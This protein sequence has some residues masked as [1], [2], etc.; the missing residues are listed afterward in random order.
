MWG[1]KVPTCFLFFKWH[2]S[3]HQI[4]TRHFKLFHKL[5]CMACEIIHFT[6]SPFMSPGSCSLKHHLF[7]SPAKAGSKQVKTISLEESWSFLKLEFQTSPPPAPISGRLDRAH[8][9]GRLPRLQ[10]SVVIF[11]KTELQLLVSKW[12]DIL[13]TVTKKHLVLV[14]QHVKLPVRELQVL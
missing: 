3:V 13:K 12:L 11:L 9:M 1:I 8:H 6:R 14:P 4:H 5:A 10:C 2:F 7:H